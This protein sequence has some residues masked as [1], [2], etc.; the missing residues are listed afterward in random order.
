MGMPFVNHS[1]LD[2]TKRPACAEAFAEP[3]ANITSEAVFEATD[4]TA[5]PELHTAATER[6]GAAPR[7]PGRASAACSG[8][9]LPASSVIQ[10][11]FSFPGMVGCSNQTPETPEESFMGCTFMRKRQLF[12]M[13]MTFHVKCAGCKFWLESTAR[14]QISVQFC[15]R[16]AS[17]SVSHHAQHQCLSVPRAAAISSSGRVRSAISQDF[18]PSSEISARMIFKPPPT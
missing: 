10:P 17:I 2:V 18:P 8:S 16:E 14:Q 13:P 3:P 9:N 7:C 1:G 5:A 4:S 6:F 15:S 12:I 11:P